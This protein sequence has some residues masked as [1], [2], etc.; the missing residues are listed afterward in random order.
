MEKEKYISAPLITREEAIK[1]LEFCTGQ[2]LGRLPTFTEKFQ[3][4]CSKNLFYQPVENK[5]WTSSFWTGEIWLAYEYSK[6]EAL[7]K[8]ALVQCDS[9]YHRIKDRIATGDHDLGFLY[10]LSCV[11]GYKITGEEKAKEAALEAA[12]HLMRLYSPFGKFIRTWGEEPVEPE[13]FE[14]IIDCLLNIPLFYW[15]S[16]VTGNKKY[17]EAAVQ[18]FLTTYRNALREDGLSHQAMLFDIN[19]GELLNYHTHQG[20]KDESAWSRGQAWAIYG[21]A[22]T[23]KYTGMKECLDMFKRA[24]DYFMNHLP[25]DMI[26][27][28]DL[29][30]TEGEEWPRDSSAATIAACGMLEMAK[31][32]SQEEA[33]K[34]TRYAKQIMKSLFENCRVKNC[35]ESNGLLMHGTYCCKTPFNTQETDRGVDECCS[36]GDYFYMEALMRLVTDW[37]MYW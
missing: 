29:T 14:M 27:Y 16:E 32:L 7:K 26:P 8:A 5:G 36:F 18:H 25:D 24:C 9:F 30:F 13:R 34:Y 1:A 20:Y 6:D 28:F 11:A 19:T 37:K 21:P 23:Y 10:T 31:Y 3:S 35:T 22:I 33:E 17:R 2:I 15:A 4:S 12:E